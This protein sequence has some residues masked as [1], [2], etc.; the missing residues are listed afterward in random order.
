MSARA[1]SSSPSPPPLPSP[2]PPPPLRC[3]SL[4]ARVAAARCRSFGR[5]HTK[6]YAQHASADARARAATATANEASALQ[7]RAATHFSFLVDRQHFRGEHESAQTVSR[8][9]AQRAMSQSS[10]HH[11]LHYLG[12][13]AVALNN[14]HQAPTTSSTTTI[15]LNENAPAAVVGKKRSIEERII[16]QLDR[17]K[18]AHIFFGSICDSAA[19]LQRHA[20]RLLTRAEFCRRRNVEWRANRSVAVCRSPHKTRAVD[21]AAS[22]RRPRHVNIYNAKNGQTLSIVVLYAFSTALKSRHWRNLRCLRPL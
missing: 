16:E 6:R 14:D 3:S 1:S 20:A 2:P 15:V 18:G 11:Q 5:S 22:R 4:P 7:P 10:R 8:A 17:L 13:A 19:S 9:A 21:G 12:I